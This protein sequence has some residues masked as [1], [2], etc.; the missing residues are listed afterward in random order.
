MRRPQN[1]YR[2]RYMKYIVLLMLLY[3]MGVIAAQKT[4]SVKG[5]SISM[6]QAIEL[7]EKNS[8]YTFFYNA[9]DLKH[10]YPKNIDCE[11]TIS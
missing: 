6:K 10:V 8:D 11:G 2:L 3:P 9:A 7:I 1:P 5:Q 4:V